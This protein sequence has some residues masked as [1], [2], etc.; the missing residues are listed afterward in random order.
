MPTKTG[1][2]SGGDFRRRFRFDAEWALALARRPGR[3]DRARTE[4]AASFAGS[5]AHWAARLAKEYRREFHSGAALDSFVFQPFL[6][7]TGIQ[8]FAR[9]SRVEPPVADKPAAAD[10]AAAAAF[11]AGR[12]F[13]RAGLLIRPLFRIVMARSA[14]IL[15]FAA[16]GLAILAAAGFFAQ[17]RHSGAGA[18]SVQP[19]DAA[20]P[21]PRRPGWVKIP[22]PFHLFNLS[23]P[24]IAGQKLDYE[25]RRHSTG[26]GR[27]DF[28]ALGEFDGATPFIRLAVY[29]HGSEKIAAPAFYVDMARRAAAIGISLDRADPPTPQATRFGEFEMA[30]LSMLKGR[31]ARDNCRGFRLG[32]APPGVGIAGFACGADGQPLSSRQVACVINRLDLVSAR[33]DKVLRDFFAAAGPR[34]GGGCAEPAPSRRRRK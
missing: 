7:K 22:E 28:L 34:G 19:T 15:K 31:L 24:L 8:F 29:R 5:V 9:R 18:E 23:A 30:A 21:A 4:K 16:V 20:K 12:L 2:D 10:G 1:F 14:P 3:L 17:W 32:A 11:G 13:W 6:R 25:A 26:G 33:G 27:E